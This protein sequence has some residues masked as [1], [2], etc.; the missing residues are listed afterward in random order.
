MAVIDWGKGL[1]K[2]GQLPSEAE[3][4]LAWG[5]QAEVWGTD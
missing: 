4:L 3:N 2:V 5:S 1:M